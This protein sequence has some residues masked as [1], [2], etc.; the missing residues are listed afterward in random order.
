MSTLRRLRF[1]FVLGGLLLGSLGAGAQTA[2]VPP[3]TIAPQTQRMADYLA[4]ALRLNKRQVLKLRAA[5]Q[6]RLDATEMLGH[7]L[8][9][10]DQAATAAYDAADYQYYAVMGKT[11]TPSQFHQLLQ[12]DQPVSPAD[13]PVM[14]QK[15]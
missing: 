5:L 8:F 14:V 6:K 15:P 3:P 2:P 13:A 10:S 7:L 4:D 11:L 12:L 9:V 1:G